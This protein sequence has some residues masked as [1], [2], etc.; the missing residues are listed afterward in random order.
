VAQKSGS[1]EKDKAL[2]EEIQK[3]GG[4]MADLDMLK[5]VDTGTKGKSTKA[6]KLNTA[7]LKG[8]L[9]EFAKSLGLATS[10]PDFVGLPAAERKNSSE[11]KGKKEKRS[12]SKSKATEDQPATPTAVNSAEK[13]KD[14]ANPKKS[15]NKFKDM[16]SSKPKASTEDDDEDVVDI[17]GF[18]IKSAK[19][20]LPLSKAGRLTVELNPQWFSIELEEL[21]IDENAPKPS[22]EEILQKF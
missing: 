18:K 20:S 7:E 4:D 6:P 13:K 21:E 17:P 1:N 12:K 11:S 3:L 2:W 16:V 14:E 9:S 10:I 22:E 19:D 5:D 8:D 15:K